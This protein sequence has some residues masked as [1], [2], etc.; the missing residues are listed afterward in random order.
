VIEN[1]HCE[2][3][4]QLIGVIGEEVEAEAV[5]LKDLWLCEGIILIGKR[6]F[7]LN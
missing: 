5:C 1:D 2:D 4:Q 7:Y 6:R 3:L